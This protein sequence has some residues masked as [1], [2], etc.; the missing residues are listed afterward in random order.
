MRGSLQLYGAVALGGAVGAL[1]RAGLVEAWTPRPGAWPWATFAANVAG[2]FLLGFFATRLQERL[3][4][5]T[6]QRPLLGTGFCGALTTFSTLDL[7]V[8]RLVRQHC[9]GLAAGYLAASLVCGFAAVFAATM[10]V[11]RARLR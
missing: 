6:L 9:T 10:L 4:P 11:R 7:E 3:P 5:S 1:A 2:A 8:L